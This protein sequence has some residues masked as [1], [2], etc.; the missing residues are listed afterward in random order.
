MFTIKEK[1]TNK[2]IANEK[3][4]FILS[5]FIPLATSPPIFEYFK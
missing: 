4:N 5:A 2:I 3:N 1:Q